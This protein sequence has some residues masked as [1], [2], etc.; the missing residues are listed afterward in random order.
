MRL[1]TWIYPSVLQLIK[2]T[3]WTP[4]IHHFKFNQLPPS[5]CSSQ[6]PKPWYIPSNPSHHWDFQ[7]YDNIN[8]ES[9]QPL[10]RGHLQA[11]LSRDW[12]QVCHSLIRS[13][14]P[15]NRWQPCFKDKVCSNYNADRERNETLGSKEQPP[16]SCWFISNIPQCSA[17]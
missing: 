17:L 2:H 15:Q 6:H 9:D 5:L 7:S 14:F 13:D 1:Q 8:T 10:N 11:L 16:V 12:A 4:I 3:S